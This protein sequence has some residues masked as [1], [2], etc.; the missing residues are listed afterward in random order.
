MASKSVTALLAQLSGHR[1]KKAKG[2]PKRTGK[3]K[4]KIAHYFAGQYFRNKLRRILRRN[5][6][7]AAAD[8]AEAHDCMA[9]LHQ[10]RG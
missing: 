7:K 4:G 1:K 2:L 10:I 8:W 3:R 6:T 5:G 9:H